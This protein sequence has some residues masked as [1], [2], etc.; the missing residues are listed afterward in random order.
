MSSSQVAPDQP[1]E[2][3]HL[4]HLLNFSV[5][6]ALSGVTSMSVQAPFLHGDVD[7]QI[8]VDVETAFSHL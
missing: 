4:N 7:E 2:H 5:G 3:L 1:E 6:L 8:D